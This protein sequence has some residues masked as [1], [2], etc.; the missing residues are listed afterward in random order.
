MSVVLVKKLTND[1]KCSMVV[2]TDE[3]RVRFQILESWSSE[4]KMLFNMDKCPVIHAG[5]PTKYR[6]GG[7]ELEV[8]DAEKDV[9][10]MI[11]ANLKPSVQ[12]ARVA[13]KANMVLGQLARGVTY[14]DRVTFVRLYQVFVLPHLSYSVPAWAPYTMADKELLEKVQ[15]RAIMM[16]SNIKGS[17]EER[18]AN[19]GMRTLGDRRMRGDLI[20]TYKIL[21]GK[22]DVKYQTWFQLARDEVGTVDTRAKT[23]HLNLSR[24]PNATSDVRKNFFSQR[25]VPHWNQLPDHVKMVQKTNDFKNAYDRHIGYERNYV[26]NQ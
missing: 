14:R 1:I 2:E 21:T 4:W 24:P 20:E 12:C 26:V 3:D 19:L 7:G 22:S 15:R 17:Y 9:G 5:K 25:V 11:T 8:T 16:V 13:K 23:G 6:W 18:L 10:V